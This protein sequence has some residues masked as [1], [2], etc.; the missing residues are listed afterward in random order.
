[1]TK[2]HLPHYIPDHGVIQKD[3][4]IRLHKNLTG[5]VKVKHVFY[6]KKT[7]KYFIQPTNGKYPYTRFNKFP[8]E[9]FITDKNCPYK[10]GLT[11]DIKF[12]YDRI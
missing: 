8:S 1:M 5:W 2:K 12:S 11:Q 6:D 3:T 7:G 9:S 10:M 4:L